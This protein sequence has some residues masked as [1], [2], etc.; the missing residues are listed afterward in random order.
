MSVGIRLQRDIF[1]VNNDEKIL[2]IWAR[3]HF[4]LYKYL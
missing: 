2:K 4:T 3:V 1:V